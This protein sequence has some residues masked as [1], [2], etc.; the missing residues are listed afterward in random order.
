MKAMGSVAARRCAFLSIEYYI[1]SITARQIIYKGC[2]ISNLVRYEE[3][4]LDLRFFAWTLLFLNPATI[5]IYTFLPSVLDLEKS[6]KVEVGW[7]S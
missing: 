5:Q 6:F 4:T 7:L 3:T 2:P 1:Q